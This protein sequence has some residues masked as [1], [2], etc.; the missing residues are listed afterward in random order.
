MYSLLE[1]KYTGKYIE[2]YWNEYQKCLGLD[3]DDQNLNCLELEE[4]ISSSEV[5]SYCTQVFR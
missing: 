3:K 5:I 4:N 1:I 2:E